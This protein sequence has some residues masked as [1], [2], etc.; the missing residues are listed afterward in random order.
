MTRD[1]IIVA[2]DG[3]K[4][5]HLKRVRNGERIDVTVKYSGDLYYPTKRSA[6]ATNKPFRLDGP[7]AY[8]EKIANAWL[9]SLT[10]AGYTGF[11]AEKAYSTPTPK[12]PA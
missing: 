3:R 11:R 4:V 7:Q 5:A 1:T 6:N 9:G 8:T 10:R 2:E 12:V